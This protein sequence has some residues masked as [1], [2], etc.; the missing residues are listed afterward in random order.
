MKACVSS[1]TCVREFAMCCYNPVL[2]L[3]YR[4]T[5]I[6]AVKQHQSRQFIGLLECA[7]EV[8][9]QVW[10]GMFT[11]ANFKL[12]PTGHVCTGHRTNH[13]RQVS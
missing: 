5:K 7:F 4:A 2:R 6:S 3:D 12:N 11:S 9:L 1:V 13:R 10:L 8:C